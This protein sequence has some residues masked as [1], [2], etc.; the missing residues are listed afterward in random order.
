[1][2]NEVVISREASEVSVEN[3]DAKSWFASKAVQGGIVAVLMW[4]ATLVNLDLAAWEVETIVAATTS[5]IGAAA[6]V[7]AIIGRLTAKKPIK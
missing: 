4:L 2:S 6:S 5:I 1:M 3:P 7:Y